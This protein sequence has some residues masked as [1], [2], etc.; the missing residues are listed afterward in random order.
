MRKSQIFLAG[1][2]A[3]FSASTLAQETVYIDDTLY[4]PLRSGASNEYRIINKGLKSGTA[5]T[6]IETSEDNSWSKVRTQA[7]VEG[8]IPNQYIS[9]QETAQR[10]L[11]RTAAELA[12]VKKQLEELQQKNTNLEAQNQ[13]ISSNASASKTQSE[14]L[15]QEL[16]RIRQISANAIEL[17]KRY[18]ELLEK[19]EMTQTQ[20]DSLAAENENLK[21]D[22]Q[23]SFMFYGAGILILGM[24][25]AI[26]IPTLKPKKRYSDWA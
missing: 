13:S 7:G 9:T 14:E 16:E 11:D 21:N 1:M 20:R 22:K 4:V 12:R 6:R 19:H 26:V 23:L 10:K 2:L 3:L 18:R 5:L 25:L 8:W 24:V 15:S 17:D